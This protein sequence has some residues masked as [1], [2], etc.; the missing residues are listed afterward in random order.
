MPNPRIIAVIQARLGSSRL[1]LKSLLTLKDVPVMDWVT[2]RVARAKNLSGLIVALPDTRLDA[3]LAEHL[4]K[5]AV[6]WLAGP[7]NDVLRR[8]C[9]AARKTDADLI[10]RV[11][12]D[13][14]LIWWEAIDRL[15][16][17]YLAR[18]VDYAY[19]HISLGNLWPD[20]LGAEIISR[21]LLEELDKQARLPSQREHCLNY[22]WD[23][24]DKFKIATFDP[25]EK[26]LAQPQL[27]LDLDSVDDYQYLG[28]KP[29]FPQ[30]DGKELMEIFQKKP[31]AIK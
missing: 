17:F 23:N 21:Q 29:I 5:Q 11:C 3:I 22:I 30:I 8:F 18:Q 7:E 31:D 26:W 4:E 20:G 1:P 9:L 27:K 10:V 25:E 19:N 15:I 14:P 6:N 16:L 13:N 24:P 2:Q 28:L 12:A